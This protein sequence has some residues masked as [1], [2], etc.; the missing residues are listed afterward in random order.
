MPKRDLG[1]PLN[2]VFNVART[3]PLLA[4]SVTRMIAADPI[5]FTVQMARRSPKWLGENLYRLS[6]SL[7]PSTGKALLEY[8]SDHPER[9]RA[10]LQTVGQD[11]NLGF[12]E[13][14]LRTQLGLDAKDAPRRKTRVRDALAAGDFKRAQTEARGRLAARVE[15]EVQLHTRGRAVRLPSL[16]P[17]KKGP[18]RSENLR[19]L[20]FLTNSLPWTQSGYTLR[21]HSILSSQ[22]ARGIG[23]EAVTRLAYPTTIGRPWAGQSDT[24]DGVVY[25]RLEPWA[26]PARTDSRI[27]LQ[28]Q[29]L[30]SHVRRFKPHV[31][32]TTTNFHN[33][34]TV[35]AVARAED[36]P[37]VYEMRGNMEQTWLAR[38]PA[39]LRDSLASSERYLGMRARETEMALA[40]DHVIALS[41]LQKEDL[42]ERGVPEAK[43]SVVPNSVDA[44]LL[45]IPR[46]PIQTR[47]TLG[48][49]DDALHG[50]SGE[51]KEFWFGTVTAVVD[52]EGLDDLIRAL[53]LVRD[54]GINAKAAVVGDGVSLPGL[55]A[56]AEDLGVAAHVVF[57]G[58]VS[59]KEAQAWYQALDAFV[60]PRKDT[61]V[62]RTVTP[63][64]GLQAMAL[65]TPVVASDL[66]ALVEVLG[67]PGNALL[68]S[69]ENPEALATRLVELHFDLDLAENLS[70]KGRKFAAT[71]TWDAAAERYEEIYSALTTDSTKSDTPALR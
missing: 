53:A 7:P 16:S 68:A 39:E 46:S 56:L 33:G 4:S 15:G 10:T 35:D 2:R 64:K 49:V 22:L 41:N 47:E 32:H 23:L 19:V 1:R 58:R 13:A 63:I 17:Q 20:H 61:E 65:G 30:R 62:T 70:E 67:S 69:P 5:F 27:A 48:L 66:P 59:P 3:A 28:A 43:I 29:M 44:E 6:L 14:E 25:H 42:V 9:A 40:A 45:A 52:Y 38:Q 34:L 57:P 50:G 31:L 36:L 21:S 55:K 12:V 8:I 37:W 24:V 54:R 60:I 51:S 18:A 71:R 26:L 11:P